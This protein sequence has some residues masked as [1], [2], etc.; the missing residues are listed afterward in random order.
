MFLLLTCMHFW[1][2]GIFMKVIRLFV[3]SH[4]V[5]RDCGNFEKHCLNL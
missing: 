5:I 4:E 3:D 2:W 1:V